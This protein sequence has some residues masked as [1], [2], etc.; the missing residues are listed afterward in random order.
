MSMARCV[1]CP[2]SEVSSV[3]GP[4]E[5]SSVHGPVGGPRIHR[6]R[7]HSGP[8]TLR[9]LDTAEAKYGERKK[10]DVIRFAETAALSDV[11]DK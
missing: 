4:I 7:G 3:H 10:N 2:R 6:G 1:Q 8:W 11:V 9:V 5:V